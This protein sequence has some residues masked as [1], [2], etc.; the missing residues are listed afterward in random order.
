MLYIK[1]MF[2]KSMC[3]EINWHESAL[4]NLYTKN[5]FLLGSI[6]EY[7]TFNIDIGFINFSR[8]ENYLRLFKTFEQKRQ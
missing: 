2:Q 8:E 1:D 7:W 5:K 3:V 6:P 4:D